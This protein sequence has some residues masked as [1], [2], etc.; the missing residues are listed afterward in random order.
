MGE[1]SIKVNIANRS[2]PLRIKF[3]EEENIRKAAKLIDQNIKDLQASYAVKDSQDLLAMTAL[4]YASQVL[5]GV[6][7]TGMDDTI[8][9]MIERLDEKV[10]N[11]LEEV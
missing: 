6:K 5:S 9:Q 4:Q 11:C 1:L 2:Y 7:N 3:S 10:K 8:V